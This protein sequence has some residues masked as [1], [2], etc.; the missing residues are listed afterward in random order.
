MDVEMGLAQADAARRLNVSRSEGHCLWNQ[1][2]TVSSV[3]RRHVSGRPRATTPAGDRFI[4]LSTRI[5]RKIS[6]LQLVADHSVASG[7]RISASTVRTLLYNS[8][9]YARR[10][11][12]HVP[13]NRR[14]RW[15]HLSWE[16]G[17]VSWTRQLWA[18]V[19]FTDESRFT[20]ENDSGRRLIWK[21]R[22]TKYHQSTTVERHSYRGGGI[23]IWAGISL[24]DHTGLH[25]FHRG[26]L[27]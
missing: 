12:V 21:E 11:V 16:R 2:Q 19:L 25:E 18:S 4:A 5:R 23:L 3:S 8:G 26:T 6:V 20:M 17:H 10:S 15:A 7:K 24:H 22:S 1:H 14:Q 27:V 13:L 9:L